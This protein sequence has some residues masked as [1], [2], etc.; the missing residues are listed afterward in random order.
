MYEFIWDLGTQMHYSEI[1]ST[2][3]ELATRLLLANGQTPAVMLVLLLGLW[4]IN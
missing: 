1:L 4:T 3:L 2:E